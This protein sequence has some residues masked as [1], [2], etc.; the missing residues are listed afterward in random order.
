MASNDLTINAD[1]LV[2]RIKELAEYGATPEGG[3]N[4]IAF[5]EE[6]V[7]ARR[8]VMSLMGHCG[9]NVRVDPVGNIFGRREGSLAGTGTILFGSH[10][11]TVPNGGAYDGVLGVLAAL[12]VAQTLTEGG[13]RSRHPLEVVVWCD[14][15]NGLTGSRG[16]VGEISAADLDQTDPDGI[17]LAEKIS[18]VGGETARINE[19]A[20][21]KDSI[22][23]YLELHVEQGSVL[24]TDGIDVGVVEG[25]VGISHYDVTLSGVPNHAGTTPMNRRS[26]ALLSAAELVLA[27][28]R[29]VKE[30]PGDQVGTVGAFD[31]SPGAPNVIPGEVTLTVELRDL[32]NDKLAPIWERIHSE[33]E[34]ISRRHG[35][36]FTTELRQSVEGSL[37]DPNVRGVISEA[38]ARLGLTTRS[39]PSGA[40]HDAQKLTQICPTGMIFVPSVDGISHSPKEHTDPKDVASGCRV[41]MDSVLAIDQW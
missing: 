31:I 7:E 32:D 27:V 14:E 1:R 8:Y 24:H 6:D 15:E 20:A 5:S 10:I 28:D 34:E 18:R 37:T 3:V 25:F 9:L 39:M 38:A 13:Y 22:A 4:R 11:D 35:T 23:A 30:T 19:V 29:I 26:N 33:L 12:E 16:Y 40:G 36:T 17:R 2:R 41:L 21:E